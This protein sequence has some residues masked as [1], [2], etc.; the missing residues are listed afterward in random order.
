MVTSPKID[1]CCVSVANNSFS[2]LEVD[3]GEVLIFKGGV[4]KGASNSKERE[5][6]SPHIFKGG[7]DREQ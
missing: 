2:G 5:I 7:L 6:E 1:G 3:G 4:K